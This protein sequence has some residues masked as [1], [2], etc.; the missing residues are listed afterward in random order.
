MSNAT[1]YIVAALALSFGAASAYVDWRAFALA[2]VGVLFD[3][4]IR[5]D[6]ARRRR[7]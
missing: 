2:C 6:N 1:R 4:I 3:N 5:L 7:A